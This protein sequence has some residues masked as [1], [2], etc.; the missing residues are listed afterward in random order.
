MEEKESMEYSATHRS[1]FGQRVRGYNIRNAGGGGKYS[2]N[3]RWRARFKPPKGKTTK[4]RFVPGQY[5]DFEGL[6]SEYYNYVEHFAKRSNMSF[7]CSK[8]HKYINGDL[9]A[10][11]GECLGC[12]EIDNGAE[13][14]SKRLLHALNGIH[15]VY[16][17]EVPVTDKQGR[18]KLYERGKRKGEQI[19]DSV[20]CEGRG[21]QYCRDGLDK[22]FGKRVHF[23]IGKGHMDILGGIVVEIEKDCARCGGKLEEVAFECA[24]CAEVLIDLAHTSLKE[25]EIARKTALPMECGE[26]GTKDTP[27][28]QRECS[29][30]DDPV[31]L[32]IFDCDIEIKREG[33]RTATTIQ[34]PRWTQTEL[35]EDLEKLA[36][37]WEFSKLFAPAT[38]EEQA[39]ILKVENPYGKSKARDYTDEPD[40]E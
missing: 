37:P 8:E 4:F 10:V 20:E 14:V 16:F 27:I 3:L 31:P 7:V 9:V 22:T 17:H 39:K 5:T 1:S 35:S 26:C 25:D 15:L 36:R 28:L 2:P 19:M 34:I 6:L 21:C 40:Y 23:S 12:D 24:K 13:D 30:C 29:D 11:G 32:S 18:P 38:L 33:E